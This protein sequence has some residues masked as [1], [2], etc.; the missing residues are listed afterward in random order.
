MLR[1]I[2]TLTA[3]ALVALA[4]AAVPL[5]VAGEDDEAPPPAPPAAPA[6]APAPAPQPAP[7]PAPKP[8]PKPT[9][10]HNSGGS[11][12][13]NSGSSPVSSPQTTTHN[14]AQTTTVPQGG[15]QAGAGGTANQGS[16][17]RMSTGL[18]IAGLSL[19]VLAGG[20]ALRRRYS[21]TE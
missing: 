16:N 21:F 9:S 15:V 13:S 11:E 19:A 17:D 10:P 20:I 12:S 18:G 6:P 1:R 2:I 7:Q 14:V 8:A 4:I 3:A 5:A